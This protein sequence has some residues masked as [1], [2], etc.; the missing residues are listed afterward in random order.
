LIGNPQQ[1]HELFT[2]PGRPF[3]HAQAQSCGSQRRTEMDSNS[4]NRAGGAESHDFVPAALA[5]YLTTTFVAIPA[6]VSAIAV[7]IV[8]I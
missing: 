5:A 8:S 2:A 1:F 6:I 3:T 4:T 7:G